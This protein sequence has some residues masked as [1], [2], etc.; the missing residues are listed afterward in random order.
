[1][2]KKIQEQLP[3]AEE[4][5]LSLPTEEEPKKKSGKEPPKMTIYEYEDKYVRRENTRAVRFFGR[6]AAVAVGVFLF[7]CLFL[8]TMK[9]IDINKYV[10]YG[11][12]AVCVLLYIFLYIVPTVKIFKTEYF[13]TNVNSHSAREA[14]KHNR[15]LRHK[16]A[17]KFIEVN[18]SV[19]GVGWYDDKLVGELAVSVHTGNEQKL[20]QTLSLLFSKSVK[21]SAKEIITKASLK[22]GM[23]TAISQT[24]AVDAALVAVVNLQ[25]IKDIVFLYGFR[26]S[27]A[28]LMRIFGRVLRNSLI[29]YGMGSVKIGNTIVKTMG[30]MAK[31][32]PLLGS[33]ISVLVDSSVQG[34][35]NAT[36]TAIIGY[37]TIHY[38]NYEYKLQDILDGIEL[39]SAEEFRD[40]CEEVENELKKRSGKKFP[41][42]ATA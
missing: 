9:V 30:D 19:D 21:K 2:A 28:K 38:L 39:E 4:E 26:P 40:T 17:D 18:A 11:V 15:E 16:I 37:Q 7:T 23:Y 24:N 3:P 25:M 1:M 6:L 14:Q 22:S 42:K 33:V 27:D 32:I 29:A 10:G 5:P 35:T 13:V 41:A 31:G 36:L 20:K 34:L 8:I 12:A